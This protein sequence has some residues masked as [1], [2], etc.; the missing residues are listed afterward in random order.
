M[1]PQLPIFVIWLVMLQTQKTIRLP[2]ILKL[3][4]IYNFLLLTIQCVN[5]KGP[6][7]I[8][9]ELKNQAMFDFS[10]NSQ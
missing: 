10:H 7:M 2:K 4:S 5:I 1:K 3:T 8:N 9:P 6:Q